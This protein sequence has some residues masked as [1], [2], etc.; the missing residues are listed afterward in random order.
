LFVTA[1]L[2]A[3][4]AKGIVPMPLPVLA[5]SAFA[6]YVWDSDALAGAP[7]RASRVGRWNGIGYY[8]LV[9][10]AVIDAGLGL[11]W[12]APVVLRGAGWIFVATTLLSMADRGYG[13]W[14][15]RRG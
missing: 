6:Q 7:L 14:R 15:L 3:L 4:A 2:A 11:H 8:A 1:T 13:L 9:G 5:I 10:T 12:A